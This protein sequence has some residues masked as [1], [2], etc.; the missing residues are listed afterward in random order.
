[1]KPFEATLLLWMASTVSLTTALHLNSKSSHYEKKAELNVTATDNLSISHDQSMKYILLEQGQRQ[2]DDRMLKLGFMAFALEKEPNKHKIVLRKNQKIITYCRFNYTSGEDKSSTLEIVDG[3][4]GE[5]YVDITFTSETKYFF[6]YYQIY[7][8]FNELD[9]V[10][11][12][13]LINVGEQNVV[14][15]SYKLDEEVKIMR[16]NAE[17][18]RNPVEIYNVV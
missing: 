15:D 1:M 13:T 12:R 18:E 9:K 14:L 6:V 7:G 5:N 2:P 4:A 8:F 10:N 16:S 3:G 17:K 11:A